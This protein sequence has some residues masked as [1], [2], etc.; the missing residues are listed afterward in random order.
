MKPENKIWRILQ[1]DDDEDDYIIVRDML[2]E[3][4][5][6][7][8]TLDWAASLDEGRQKLYADHYHA[9]LVD[10]DL[11]IGTGIELMR[12]FTARGYP[13]PMILLTG[14]GSYEVDVEAMHAGATLY[15][16]KDDI[17]PLLLERSIRYAIERKQTEQALLERDQKLSVALDAANLGTWTYCFDDHMFEMDERAQQ[18]YRVSQPRISHDTVVQNYLHPNDVPVMWSALDRAADP[19]GDGRYHMEYR[20]LQPDGSVNWL[21][22]W[23]LVEFEGQGAERKAVRLT[24]ATRDIT[25]EKQAELKLEESNTALRESERSVTELAGRFQSILENSL[26]VAYRRNLQTDRYDYMSPVVE[27]VLGFT[28]DEMMNITTQEMLSRIHP[29][30]LSVVEE[31]LARSAEK[32]KGK[33]EYRLKCK[34]G[35][36]RW[37]ADYITVTKDASGNQL[38]R[39]GIIRDVTDQVQAAQA[40]KASE[41][42]FQLASRAVAGVLYDW[43]IDGIEVFQSEGLERVVGYQPG[44]E[45]AD[46]KNWWPRNIHPD[47]YDRI[48]AE[49]QTAIEGQRDSFAYEYRF[50]H[51]EGHWVNL[52]D[53]GYIVRDENGRA[54]RVVGMCTDISERVDIEQ[55]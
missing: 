30:D 16:T 29:E 43:T 53:Q 2:K 12:E 22:A 19:A 47:D 4:Q 13:A 14:R 1:V 17:N 11:G 5:G 32:G 33:L 9:V 21:N 27:Q 8:V 38:Y 36:Y 18:L 40:L 20:I 6:R 50:Q 44:E 46:G 31:K 7:S 10:Y 54:R 15:L 55:A 41:E 34:D 24:G 25:W 26:D 51:K 3:A 45:Q 23:G 37:L 49:L 42:R 28:P 48:Q 35:R 52:L 39:T